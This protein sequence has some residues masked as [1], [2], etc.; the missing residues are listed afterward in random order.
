MNRSS[1]IGS[2]ALLGA[3]L[4]AGQ[5]HAYVRST[6][7]NLI[8]T[9]WNDPTIGLQ[10]YVGAPPDYLDRATIVKAVHA[11]AAAWSKPAVG[12]T[13]ILLN[14]TDVDEAF[15]AA[16]I[17]MVNRIGF[18]TDEWKKEPCDVQKELCAP[19]TSA[20]IAITTVTS[21]TRTGEILDADME[22]NAVTRKFVDIVT[23]NNAHLGGDLHDL[24]NT[25]THELGHLIGLDHTCW[26]TLPPDMKP[27]PLD[28]HGNPS[29]S[30]GDGDLPPEIKAATM[31]AQ[32]TAGEIDKRTLEPDDLL[33]VCE[34]YP[35]GYKGQRTLADENQGGCTMMAGSRGQRAAGGTAGLAL[36]G[37]AVAAALRFRGRR[38]R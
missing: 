32:A 24:Q 22:I 5:A 8:P 25:V 27:I 21:S 11:A 15:A 1:L 36:L 34:I 23:D 38:G 37:L 33:A 16:S 7:K 31:Y 19:Y 17:D 29:P 18:R 28:N 12:C 26:N 3:S 4:L 6:T 9:A 10:L 14:V 13:D 30:C 35:M 2:A 20:A